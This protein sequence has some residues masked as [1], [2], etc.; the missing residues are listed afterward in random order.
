MCWRIND[1]RGRIDDLRRRMND[2]R[3]RIDDSCGR[4]DD[5]CGQIDS[6]RRLDR[7]VDDF[8]KVIVSLNNHAKNGIQILIVQINSK[9]VT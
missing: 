6:L 5:L 7:P 1:L 3:G 4:I 8:L 9:L 2:S